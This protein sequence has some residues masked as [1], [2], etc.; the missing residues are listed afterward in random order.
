MKKKRLDTRL[1]SAVL[2][3]L[4]LFPLVGLFIPIPPDNSTGRLT[5]IGALI[6]CCYPIAIYQ[7]FVIKQVSIDDSS[8]YIKSLFR[9]DEQVIHYAD[10]IELKEKNRKLASTL[11]Y[12]GNKFILKY[13][14]D[15]EI[16]SATFYGSILTR[17]M[18][19]FK[20]QLGSGRLK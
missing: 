16:K 5:I 14:V 7:A 4:I 20:R 9:Q 1:I 19:N 2:V 17:Q 13:S 8:I 18:D 3:L 11:P 10:V 6:L 12:G 15:K